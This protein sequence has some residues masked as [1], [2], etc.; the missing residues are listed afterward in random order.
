MA[1]WLGRLLRNRRAGEAT[2]AWNRKGLEAPSTIDLRSTAFAS[3]GLI[4]RLHAG[5]R[6]GDNVAPQLSWNGV[7]EGATELVLLI[8]DPDVP[9]RRPITHLSLSGIPAATTSIPQGGLN[10]GAEPFG[11]GIGSFGRAGYAGP[12]PI[13]GHGP[14]SYVFQ[15]F[16]LDSPL[17]LPLAAKP[18]EITE[19]MSGHV[20][21]RGRLDGTYE[22]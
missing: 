6:V 5:Q 11:T 10:A 16:A 13:P 3:G 22:R 20:L 9:L 15:I 1:K 12:R 21:V 4:P 14:H 2:L 18:E 8:E 19:A 7:P 17:T